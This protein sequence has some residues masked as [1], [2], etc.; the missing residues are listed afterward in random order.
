MDGQA[1]G[2]RIAQRETSFLSGKFERIQNWKTTLTIDRNEE[3]KV[4]EY[5]EQEKSAGTTDAG[6]MEAAAVSFIVKVKT[7]K[8]ATNEKA[9]NKNV[10]DTVKAKTRSSTKSP[11]TTSVKPA[12]RRG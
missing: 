8:K 2:R 5:I 9:T 10:T 12:C 3:D 11:S 6:T 1:I 7:D 4:W